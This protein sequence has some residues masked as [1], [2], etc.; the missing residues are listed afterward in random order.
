LRARGHACIRGFMTEDEAPKSAARLAELLGDE[1]PLIDTV[2]NEAYDL[3]ASARELVEAIVMTDV[4]AKTRA[5][6]A[7]ELAS[8][9]DRLRARRR[10]EALYLVRHA[11]GRVES[12]VQ[13]GAG[14]L[15]P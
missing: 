15:N 12:L 13:A 7:A 14:R 3:V 9:A 10:E 5:E 1:L 11:A 6:V 4:D 2:P 8:I